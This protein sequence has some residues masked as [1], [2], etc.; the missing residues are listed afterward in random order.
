MGVGW[1]MWLLIGFFVMLIV[2]MIE[3]VIYFGWYLFGNVDGLFCLLVD[4]D[5]DVVIWL[6]VD[7]CGFEVEVL[8]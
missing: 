3:C 2:V 6:V 5:F 4:G 1:V 8:C 7:W